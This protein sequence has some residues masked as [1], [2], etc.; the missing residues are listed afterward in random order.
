MG[1]SKRQR[2]PDVVQIGEKMNIIGKKNLWFSFS[3]I[4]I[5]IS[6]FAMG[7]NAF[8]RGSIMNFGID[9]T[10]GT[11]LVLRFEN[12][13]GSINDVRK[14]LND[15]GLAKSIIQKT[16]ESDISIKC[17]TISTDTRTQILMEL[18]SK[19]GKVELLEA[20][21]VGPVIGNE[22]R[23]QAIWALVCA[24]IGIIIYVSFRFEFRYALAAII[25]LYHDAIIMVGMMALL[26]R[27]IE[28][29]FIAAILTIMG[30]SINDTIIIFDRIR[31]NIKK[32]GKLNKNFSELVNESVNQTMARSINT[33]LTVV[34]MNVCILLFGGTM[35][36]D[37][38]LALL[39]GF[40]CGAYSSIFLASPLLVMW[41]KNL[42][43]RK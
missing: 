10:G 13:K 8:A 29:P 34:V 9:F 30:Y 5:L 22:L 15:F 32:S 3:I 43:R 36:Q 37:F 23:M 40:V 24:T 11:M 19:I 6:I 27:N 14:V 21:I 35:I 28:V 31:E 26:W 33:V 2:F 38:A 16:G 4:M 7:F 41:T 20:D 1:D 25:A 42:V 18:E 12:N 17:E 39:I